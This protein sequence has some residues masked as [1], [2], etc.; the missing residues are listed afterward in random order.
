MKKTLMALILGALAAGVMVGCGAKEEGDTTA[1]TPPA[2]TSADDT[3][4]ETPTANKMAGGGGGGQAAGGTTEPGKAD[5]MPAQPEGKTE[6]K[7]AG[8]GEKPAADGEKKEEDHTGHNH[9]P[10]EGH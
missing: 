7:P 2:T 9:A 1:T 8:E 6:T 5:D 10:G 4:K 3:P